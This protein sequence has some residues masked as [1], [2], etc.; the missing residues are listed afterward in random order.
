MFSSGSNQKDTSGGLGIVVKDIPISISYTKTNKL[1]TALYM[2][3]DIIERDEPL[4]GKLRTLGTGILS[5]IHNMPYHA[6]GKISE[7]MS[8]LD[9]AKAL[10]IISQ[11]NCEI[12][13]KEFAELSQSIRESSEKM[14]Q[15]DRELNLA[16]FF[17]KEL[18]AGRTEGSPDR[19][20]PIGHVSS[21]R[22]GVQRGRTLLRALSDKTIQM[23]DKKT[24]KNNGQFDVLKKNRRE[25]IIHFIKN[26]S[27]GATITDIRNG[28]GPKVASCGEKTLQREL[29]SM[30]KEGLLKKIGEKRW[31]RYYLKSAS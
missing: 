6:C 9:L 5:D 12:L 1:I 27:A 25:E 31:S 28:A 7:L 21:A 14:E 10:N 30:L 17:A 24:S 19:Q 2:V 22:I 4:R 29:V 23:S 8:F 16:E 15:S 11:M 13:Q 26:T 18:P 3:T 20:N